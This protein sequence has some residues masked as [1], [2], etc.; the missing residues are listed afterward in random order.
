MQEE[1]FIDTLRKIS[2]EAQESLQRE[3]DAYLQKAA[4]EGVEYIRHEA[5]IMAQK[6][7]RAM[8]VSFPFDVPNDFLYKAMD[9]SDSKERYRNTVCEALQAEGFLV[10]DLQDLGRFEISW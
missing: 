10:K 8:T 5:V 6:G 2:I 7:F 3:F 1:R 9:H 4:K